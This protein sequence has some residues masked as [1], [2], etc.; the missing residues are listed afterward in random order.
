[1]GKRVGVKHQPNIVWH[2]PETIAN[3][4]PDV[5]AA[6]DRRMK[7]ATPTEILAAA[8]Q[9]TGEYRE[10]LGDEWSDE[11]RGYVAQY[12]TDRYVW[13]S[14]APDDPKDPA[15]H[16]EVY[17]GPDDEYRPVLQRVGDES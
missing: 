4:L 13:V 15:G 14:D 3:T 11:A 12:G 8:A 1:M 5:A 16:F 6:F 17:E 10:Y 7:N 9:L 2:A